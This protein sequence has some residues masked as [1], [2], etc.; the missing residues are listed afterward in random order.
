MIT[1][2]RPSLGIIGPGKVG[3]T[4]ARLFYKHGWQITAISGRD[5]ERAA[6]LAADLGAA[7]LS[8]VEVVYR[9]DLTLITVAEDAIMP[10]AELIAQTADDLHGKAIVHASGAHSAESLRALSEKGAMVGS[11]HPAYPIADV[12]R[13][14]IGLHG[15][16]FA[17]EAADPRLR[18]WLMEMV[19]AVEG[20][21]LLIPVGEKA[22]YHAA[23]CIA[24]NYTVTLYALAERLLFGLGA[25]QAAVAAALN[26][27]LAGTVDN[28]R[29]R[30]I[31]DALTGP[32]VRADIGTLKAHLTTLERFDPETAYLYK[33]L[34]RGTF[35]LLQQRG[36]PMDAIEHLFGQEGYDDPL[37]GT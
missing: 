11:L 8:T 14:M 36:T 15:A 24:S 19:A 23:L 27:L 26:V 35:P 20:R 6:R 3:E 1:E 37:D 10:V 13:A 5:R 25:D 21:F 7:V 28:L 12:Q 18:G 16:A 32:L 22:L 31:P 29:T 4:F 34:A 30:G 2:G 33:A 17:V 9:A